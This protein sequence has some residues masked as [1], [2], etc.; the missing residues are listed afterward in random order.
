MPAV[1]GGLLDSAPA[2]RKQGE[3]LHGLTVGKVLSAR[4]TSLALE[5]D[6]KVIFSTYDFFS[7]QKNPGMMINV[8]FELF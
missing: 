7:H 4:F 2:A 5:G 8:V 6:N 1:P 3:R